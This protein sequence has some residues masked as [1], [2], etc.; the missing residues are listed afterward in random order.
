MYC[1]GDS[2]KAG[3]MTR[4]LFQKRVVQSSVLMKLYN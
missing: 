1:R 3:I 2:E 4:R